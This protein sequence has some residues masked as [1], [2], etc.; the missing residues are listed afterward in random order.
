MYKFT[1]KEKLYVLKALRTADTLTICRRYKVSRTTIWRWRKRY[2]GTLESLEPQ[3]S[4][5]GIH[6]PN[7]QTEEE[8]SNIHKLLKRNP[9]IGLNEL[10]GKLYRNYGYRRNP[11]TL[12]RYL[13]RNNIYEVKRRK[14]YKPK[15]YD[16]PIKL[17][18]KWQLDVKYVPTECYTGNGAKEEKYYQYT[19]IDEADRKRFIYPY[20]EISQES[21][22]DFVLRAFKF[23][24]YR[25]KIIQTD[26][27]SEF[28][29]RNYVTK[30]GR[31]HK[32]DQLCKYFHIKHRLNRPRTPRHNGKVERSHRNDNERFYRYLHF[33]SFEDLKIQMAAYLKRSNDIP[34][35]VLRS[36]DN[37]NHWL[38]PNEKEVEL[39]TI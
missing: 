15:K 27:G 16:T 34:T 14:A 36:A 33:Y 13:K 30:D 2:D 18:E 1:A 19:V 25:P 37:K 12:Y 21:T 31:I 4:R 39:K 24:G 20:M 3:F 6:H 11:V 17:G 23:F 28:T 35:S 9:N 26:N 29:F 5:K 32:L 22:V 10:Y 38:S 7:E 8:K